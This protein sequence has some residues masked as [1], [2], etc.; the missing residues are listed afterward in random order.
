MN[1]AS[2]KTA[3]IA[4]G[5]GVRVS[6]FVSGCTHMCKNCF[7]EEAWDFNYGSFFDKKAEEEVLTLLKPNHI[8]GLSLLGGE[9]L[10]PR[11]QIGLI[12]LLRKFKELYPNKTLWCYSGYTYEHLTEVMAKELPYTEE[13]LSYID[14]LV[15]GKYVDEL[16]DITLRFRGSA[17]QRLIDVKQTRQSGNIV[18]WN[19]K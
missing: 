15:D 6:L 9:P 16:K 19:D 3:D 2:I 10:D 13:I 1:Y 5:I 11:N 4:N 17:N 12:P 8:D 7:N 14:V 18:I